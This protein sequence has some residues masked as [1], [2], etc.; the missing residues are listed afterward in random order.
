MD[1]DIAFII[2]DNI[3]A[4]DIIETIKNNG[5]ENIKFVKL[6]DRY[7]GSQIQDGKVSLAFK[8]GF[9]SNRKTLKDD[10]IKAAFNKIVDKLEDYYDIDLRS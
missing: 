10:E 5:G 3:E 6:F 2:N 8:I 1:R 4:Q 9:Q 7:A